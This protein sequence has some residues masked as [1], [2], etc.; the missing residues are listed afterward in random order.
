[1]RCQYSDAIWCD[2]VRDQYVEN[3][4]SKYNQTHTTVQNLK[5]KEEDSGLQV[6]PDAYELEFGLMS[7]Y[8]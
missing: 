6:C 1:M 3:K 8:A 5:V 4:K 2:G 7:V